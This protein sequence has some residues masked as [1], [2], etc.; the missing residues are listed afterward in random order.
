MR[1]TLDL[2]LYLD[3][4][5]TYLPPAVSAAD[6]VAQGRYDPADHADDGYDHVLV[7]DSR[8]P[9]EMAVLAGRAALATA[10][11]TGPVDLVLHGSS[12]YQGQDFWT[13]A[14]YVRRELVGGTGP[15]FEVRS[16]SNSGMAALDLA[17]AYLTAGPG[18][19]AALITVADR[20]AL[21]GFDRWA[22]DG[23]V[24]Y[25]DGAAA[26]LLSRTGGVARVLAVTSSSDP[27]LESLG[28]DVDR[29]LPAPDPAAGPL[30]LR[31]FKARYLRR[32]GFDELRARLWA[33]LRTNVAATA[34]AAR[35]DL[36]AV[37]RYLVPNVGR[38]LLEWEFLEPLGIGVDRTAWDNARRI[39]HLGAADQFAN[40]ADMI[41]RGVLTAGQH[42]LLIGVG[43]GFSWTSALLRVEPGDR[44]GAAPPRPAHQGGTGH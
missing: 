21:P 17:A 24:V 4:V 9:A 40:L 12:Y 18:R 15:A 28:R 13:P 19:A 5:G 39:G 31:G 3:A 30:D 34:R 43:L 22:S 35:V 23:G 44:P 37:D 41:E 14:T 7:E 1:G 33:G 6:A 16:A 27:E 20:F 38:D 8:S 25:A 36:A 26:V 11:H 42:V 32:A 29:F 2:D 10:R